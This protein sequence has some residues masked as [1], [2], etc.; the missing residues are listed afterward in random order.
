MSNLEAR[1]QALEDIEA[2]K[3]LK[4]RY[5][6]CLDL[7][8]WDELATCFAPDARVSYG[9]GQ[10]SFQGVDAILGF[11][12]EA[13]GPERGS[14]T[15]HHGHHPEITLT[16]ATTARATWA[17]DNYMFNLKQDRG[18]R[19]GAYYHDDCVKLA[20]EW[21]FASIGYTYIFHEEWKRSDLPSLRLVAG[22]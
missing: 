17:L 2:L 4:Y 16:S 1:I 13:L 20:G 5:W 3:R 9:E 11:L 15:L 18:V 6:R 19:I 22:G 14:V 10:Y 12:R 7:K 21:K 8:L